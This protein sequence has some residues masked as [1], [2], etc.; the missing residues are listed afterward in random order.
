V[1]VGGRNSGNTQRLAEIGRLSGK[2]VHHI[3]SEA[4]LDLGALSGAHRVAVTAGA[5]TPNWIINK[6]CRT[7]ELLPVEKARGW[8]R[9]MFAVQRTLLLTNIYVSL[10]AGSLCFAC[11]RLL[12]IT[13][14]PAHVLIAILYVQSMH[15]LN[16]LT[17]TRSDRYND[18]DRANFY[19]KYKWPLAILAI[20]GGGLGLLMAVT[21]GPL[22]FSILL[23]MSVMGLS[24]NLR[25]LP[26]G[27]TGGRIRRIRD[28]PG[29]KTVLIASAWGLV[30]ALFPA[31]STD[32]PPGL[33]T[34]LVLFIATGMVFTR[35]AFFAVLDVQGDRIVG[36]GSIPIILGEDKTLKLLK[37]IQLGLMVL[38]PVLGLTGLVPRMIIPMTLCPLMM[39]QMLRAYERGSMHPGI[40]LEFLVETHLVMAGLLALACGIVAV[41]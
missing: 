4:N 9:L 26:P 24:Y 12:G 27:L 32:H 35:T 41:C 7:L 2:P 38:L 17:G 37:Q 25:I 33:R 39:L 29:S 5:S 8:R 22:A 10:G 28:I 21:L 3:E 36:K 19:E 15:I 18:P 1:V 40:R 30:T 31:L 20:F 6:V 23:A 16:N 11:T 14:L 34:V 13:P